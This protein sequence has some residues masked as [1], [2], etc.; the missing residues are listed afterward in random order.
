V[1]WRRRRSPGPLVCV[2]ISADGSAE[3]PTQTGGVTGW[4]TGW[5]AA[6]SAL[7]AEKALEDAPLVRRGRSL[8]VDLG[9]HVVTDGV[10]NVLRRVENRRRRPVLKTSRLRRRR[11]NDQRSVR[12]GRISQAA[13]VSR[14]VL[15]TSPGCIGR[16]VDVALPHRVAVWVRPALEVLAL[17]PHRHR[18]RIGRS[19][20]SLGA[21]NSRDS[22][23]H[24]HRPPGL[25]PLTKLTNEANCGG[26]M[27]S[28]GRP[29]ERDDSEAGDRTR[30]ARPSKRRANGQ[31]TEPSIC[32]S[33]R[34]LHS[35]AYSIGS[36]F[37]IGSMKPF[38]IRPIACSSESP[39]DMR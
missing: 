32:S 18:P 36:I 5:G 19:S 27:K 35:T 26:R 10:E 31:P 28:V 33:I 34:R 12:P 23:R 11:R 9:P 15:R 21:T 17:R 6:V 4:G 13:R 2:G 16:Q 20:Q 8:G 38:T 3:F 24:H 39:R 14:A 7:L 29:P 22:K 25:L 37:V 1:H 30:A